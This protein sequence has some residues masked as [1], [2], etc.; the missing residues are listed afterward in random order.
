MQSVKIIEIKTKH[1]PELGSL[2]FFE[3]EKDIDFSVKRIYY[4]YGV[5]EAGQRGG[6]AHKKLQQVLF[7]PYG[8]I[9]FILDDGQSREHV[10]LDD[11]AKALVL[12]SGIWRD[13][14]WRQAGSVLCVGASAWYDAEDYIRD[15]AMFKQMVQE[16]YWHED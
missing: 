16:G 6:H 3:A 14:I 12:G 1:H 4:T 15:Y 8:A 7:C 5:P 11:P 2:S 13:M 9:E 10:L